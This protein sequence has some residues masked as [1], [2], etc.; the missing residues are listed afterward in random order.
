MIEHLAGD[1][2]AIYV[3][4]DEGHFMFNDSA[5]LQNADC[6]AKVRSWL[7]QTPEDQDN[8]FDI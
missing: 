3:A 1:V 6:V 7:E 2:T 4:L 8:N 5:Q